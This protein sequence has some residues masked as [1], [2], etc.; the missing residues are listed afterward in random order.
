MILRVSWRT[1][2]RITTGRK[3]GTG[4]LSTRVDPCFTIT[5]EFVNLENGAE[6]GKMLSVGASKATRCEELA[7]A[8]EDVDSET[9]AVTPGWLKEVSGKWPGVDRR[10][11]RSVGG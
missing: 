4:V 1:M 5:A 8:L 7:F 2:M 6:E 9:I 10:T 3:K 11:A